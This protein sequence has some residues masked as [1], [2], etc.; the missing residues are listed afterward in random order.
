MN[1]EVYVSFWTMV[2][3]GYMPRSGILGLY[4]SYIFRFLRHLYI[5]FHNSCTNL[6]SQWLCRRFPF[7]P[8]PL[9][10]LLFVDF[11]DGDHSDW[12]EIIPHCSFFFF[13]SF[14]LHFSNNA[15]TH[16][17]ISDVEHL[18]YVLFGY[19]YVLFGEMY[20]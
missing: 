20:I 4:D 9:Q 6:H 1:T 5:V 16:T 2:S 12:F 13:C 8:H 15:C 11:F 17:I 18:F 7:S 19:L 3:S 10:H 14:D